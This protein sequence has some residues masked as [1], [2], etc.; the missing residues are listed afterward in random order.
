MKV[1]CINLHTC[2]CTCSGYILTHNQPC[3][4]VCLAQMSEE[5]L[6]EALASV[7]EE[8]SGVTHL[9]RCSKTTTHA[10]AIQP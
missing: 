9:D 8:H 10:L 4:V 1:A 2:T 7:D 5:E 3:N 6:M